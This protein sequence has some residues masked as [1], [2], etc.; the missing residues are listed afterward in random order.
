MKKKKRGESELEEAL[1]VV[2]LGE[3]VARART[4]M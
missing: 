4:E 2:E 3:C 1:V